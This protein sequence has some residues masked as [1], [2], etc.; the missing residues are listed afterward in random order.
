MVRIDSTAGPGY[1]DSEDRRSPETS[2]SRVLDSWDH[3]VIVLGIVY[4]REF[5]PVSDSG[6]FKIHARGTKNGERLFFQI[7]NK[8]LYALGSSW[9]F[10]S[11][12]FATRPANHHF[13]FP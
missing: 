8:Y 4:A 6:L 3:L 9:V 13:V 1:T 7:A 5:D 10:R 11:D 2:A 12:F